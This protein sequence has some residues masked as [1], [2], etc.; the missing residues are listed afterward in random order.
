MKR[1]PNKLLLVCSI[2]LLFTLIGCSEKTPSNTVVNS[3]LPEKKPSDFNFVLNYGVN[4]K[5]QLD[6][7][8]GTYTKD[9]VAAPS[10]TTPLKLSEKEMNEIYS[11]MKDINIISYPEN[12]YPKSNMFKTPYDT[13]SIKIIANGKEK[14]INWK[15]ESVSDSKEAVQLRGLFIKIHSIVSEKEEYKKLPRQTGGYD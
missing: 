7:I 3:Q 12:F 5:N 14:T 13:Y 11:R 8:K 9:L 10:V 15:D 6:T 4:A 1:L 2:L